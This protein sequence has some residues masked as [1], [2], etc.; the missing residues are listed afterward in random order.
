MAEL[1]GITE[2]YEYQHNA[3]K[4]RKSNV[5]NLKF[6]TLCEQTTYVAASIIQLSYELQ[7]YT[8]ILFKRR[9]KIAR[10]PKFHEN[11]VSSTHFQV[12]VR[13]YLMI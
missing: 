3:T 8:N 1:A 7:K 12:T 4:N 2:G 10:V 13:K 9:F 6:A 5:R 11:F